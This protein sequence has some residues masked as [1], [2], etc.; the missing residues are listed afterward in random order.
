MFNIHK[1]RV[2]GLPPL[3]HV[4]RNYDNMLSRFNGQTELLYQNRA[5]VC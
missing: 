4:I 2:I 1:T 3:Y 5:S